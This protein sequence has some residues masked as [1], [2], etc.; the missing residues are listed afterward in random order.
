MAVRF[1]ELL[2]ELEYD[3]LSLPPEDPAAEAAREAVPAWCRA[4]FAMA[5][6][7]EALNEGG[8]TGAAEGRGSLMLGL[9]SWGLA[10]ALGA[11]ARHGPMDTAKQS[12]DR[13]SRRRRPPTCPPT[14]PPSPQPRRSTTRS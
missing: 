7:F 6:E 13:C 5:D 1:G 11:A 2:E 8:R 4:A 10:C 14:C 9:G 3:E 12:P